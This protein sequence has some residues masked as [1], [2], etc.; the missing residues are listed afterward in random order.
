MNKMDELFQVSVLQALS[1]GDYHGSISV[2]EFKAHGDMGLGTFNHLNGEMIMVDGVVYRADGEGEVTEVV[3]DT[4]PFGNAAFIEKGEEVTISADS[5]ETLRT[6][7][8]DH[9]TKNGINHMYAVKI[10]GLY[11]HITLR[12]IRAQKEP[13]LPLV[14]VLTEQQKVWGH[15]SVK[16]TIVGF[17]LPSYMDKMNTDDWHLHFI[18]DDRRI[19][20]HVLNASLEKGSAKIKKLEGLHIRLP[21]DREFRS[22]CLDV[23]QKEDIKRIES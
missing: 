6:V 10:D 17:H 20:G 11:D 12:S 13:Y 15:E 16:G 9:I 4:I 18:S 23:D 3:N 1:L 14:R 22:L 2:D 21:D 8:N 7:L 5:I 19:G